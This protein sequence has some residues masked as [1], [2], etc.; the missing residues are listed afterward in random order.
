MIF[1]IWIMALW[2]YE[3]WLKKQPQC[4]SML[5]PLFKKNIEKIMSASPD[6]IPKNIMISQPFWILLEIAP[7]DNLVFPTAYRF[8]LVISSNVKIVWKKLDWANPNALHAHSSLKWENRHLMSQSYGGW[9][10]NPNH[11]LIGGLSMFI[12]LLCLGFNHPFGG[13]GFRNHPQYDYLHLSHE[14]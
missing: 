9:L 11:Q 12:P 13:A 4:V 7:K 6:C 3:S 5:S 8:R 10:R 14:K 2:M 1:L